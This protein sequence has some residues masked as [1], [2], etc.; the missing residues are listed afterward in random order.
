MRNTKKHFL[1]VE[2]SSFF[3]LTTANINV[4]SLVYDIVEKV[5]KEYEYVDIYTYSSN[6][7]LDSH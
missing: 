5:Y 7:P 2:L 6:S 3:L 1:F 4:K